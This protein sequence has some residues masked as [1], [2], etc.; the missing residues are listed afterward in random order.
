MTQSF[1]TS[2]PTSPSPR[3]NLPRGKACMNCRRRKIKCDGRKP[4]CS[5]CSRAPGTAEDCEY[6]MEGRSRTQQLEET[7]KKLQSRIG[8]LETTSNDSSIVLHEPYDGGDASFMALEIPQFIDSWPPSSSVSNSPSSRVNTPISSASSSTL[9]L[10]EPPADVIEGLVDTFLAHFSQVGFFLDSG[11]FR[12][13]ALLSFPFGHYNR[14]SPALLSAVYMWGSRLSQAPPHPV[15]NEDAFLACTLQNIH[16]D[17]GGQHPQ[18]VMHGIQA[19]LLLSLYYLTL[20]RPVEGIYHS[21]AA[22]SLAISSGLHLIK[23][24]QLRPQPALG[25]LEAPLAPPTDPLEEGER[26]NAFWTVVVVNNYW[27][28]AHG[29]PSAIS[30]ADTPIDTP[31]PLDLDDYVASQLF[32]AILGPS[33]GT[34]SKFLGGLNVDGFSA[35]ALLSKASILLERAITFS[36]RYSDHADAEA[37]DSLDAILEQFALGVPVGIELTGSCVAPK[38]SL[39]V[40]QT[41]THAAIIRLHAHRIHTSDISRAKY[42]AAARAVV[43]IVN[44]A[45]FAQWRHIDPIMGI[46]WT[47]IC[48]VFVAE[49]STMQ[50][51]GVVGRLTQQHQDISACL[52][53]ILATMRRFAR[54]SPVIEYFSNRV[55][56][57]YSA[58]T[59]SV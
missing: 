37:F 18:R 6:P 28:A 20:G 5:Q 55:E 23:S 54:S 42:L 58:V 32:D 29:S 41:L 34:V 4:I 31:W 38:R 12:H 25:V 56:Q 40:T 14:P 52:E 19:E 43:D 50:S 30:Y 33:G 35:L 48:D 27:V 36:T 13:S 15:Y 2:S 9:V 17:L 45:D 51:F 11:V 1:F 49:L 39:V 26:I 57:A 7:I 8:E 16:Q 46:L 59:S 44:N 21:S 10:E 53:T 24:S 3:S 22:V 47:T